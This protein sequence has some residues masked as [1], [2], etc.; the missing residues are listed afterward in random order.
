MHHLWSSGADHAQS[1][2]QI[3][4]IGSLITFVGFSCIVV[5]AGQDWNMPAG[6]QAAGIPYNAQRQAARDQ[7]EGPQ[8]NTPVTVPTTT[9]APIAVDPPGYITN[10]GKACTIPA[11]PSAIFHTGETPVFPP[12]P[13][14]CVCSRAEKI[15]APVINCTRADHWGVPELDLASDCFLHASDELGCRCTYVYTS[16]VRKPS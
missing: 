9:P 15:C 10:T 5:V 12:V 11:D 2:S 13:F 1:I 16:R 6:V 4:T 8:T 3:L 14:A 7:R